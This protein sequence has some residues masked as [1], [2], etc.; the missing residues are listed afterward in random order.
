MTLKYTNFRKYSH[1]YNNEIPYFSIIGGEL[2]G[3]KLKPHKHRSE[4]NR[5]VY[6]SDDYVIKIDNPFVDRRYCYLNKY[7]QQ[8]KKEYKAYMKLNK[9]QKKFVPK[10]VEVGQ[11]YIPIFGGAWAWY[12]VTERVEGSHPRCSNWVS[13]G[14]KRLFKPVTQDLHEFNVI[15]D[16]EGKQ[17]LVDLGF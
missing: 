4:H 13:K 7:V 8:S 10:L 12:V 1:D 2:Y 9:E 15:E 6:L 14:L 3:Q 16:R 11:V 17:W 5:V